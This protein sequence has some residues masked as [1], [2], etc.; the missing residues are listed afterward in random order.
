MLD[1]F[2]KQAR[3][4]GEEFLMTVQILSADVASRKLDLLLRE[5][6]IALTT[7]DMEDIKLSLVDLKRYLISVGQRITRGDFKGIRQTT[8]DSL[9]Q[10]MGIAIRDVERIMLLISSDPKTLAELRVD[11]METGE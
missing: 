11:R 6:P 1:R 9:L 4:L 10:E 7:N 3:A 5:T 2:E 8:K